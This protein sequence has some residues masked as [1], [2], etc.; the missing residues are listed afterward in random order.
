MGGH[1]FRREKN[2]EDLFIDPLDL[3]ERHPSRIPGSSRRIRST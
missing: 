2:Y 1:R 3:G